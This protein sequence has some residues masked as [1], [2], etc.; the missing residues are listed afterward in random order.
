M[1]AAK[2]ALYIL[3]VL[4]V[5][6]PLCVVIFSSYMFSLINIRILAGASFSLV[7]AGNIISIVLRRREDKPVWLNMGLI[8]GLAAVFVLML[9]L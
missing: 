8:A 2:T 5:L 3:G 9:L 1:K 7:T 4:F 6:V